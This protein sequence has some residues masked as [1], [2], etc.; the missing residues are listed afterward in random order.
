MLV[1]LVNPLMVQVEDE[2]IMADEVWDIILV[3][4]V[5]VLVDRPLFLDLLEQWLSLLLGLPRLDVVLLLLMLNVLYIIL[6]NVLQ[7][8]S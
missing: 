7:I 5:Q 4:L 3:K 1:V 6:E 2:D 8:C